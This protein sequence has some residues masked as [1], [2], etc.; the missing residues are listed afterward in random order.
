MSQSPFA[1][2]SGRPSSAKPPRRG[3]GAVAIATSV[4]L[5]VAVLL[6][7]F[8]SNL[9]ARPTPIDF[10]VYKVDIVSPPPQPQP[11]VVDEPEPEP[12]PPAPEPTPVPKEPEPE[13][14]PAERPK[15]KPPTPTPPREQP[16]PKPRPTPPAKKHLDASQMSGEDINV[17]MEGLQSRYPEYYEN[18]IR[19]VRRFLRWS[20]PERP[21][22]TLFFYI[23]RDGSV[24][25]IR[26]VSGSGNIAFN[27]EATGAVEAAGR[28]KAFGPLPGDFEYD[29]L[30]MLFDFKPPQ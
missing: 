6:A 30:P 19:Q 22:V 21:T 10:K 7:L 16:K 23:N 20:R 28:E 24:S 1:A 26:V 3:P 25:D 5:H 4:V 13:P 2:G 17:V 18:I 15:P 14:A 12:E 11:E 8:F 9:D 29:R 27:I